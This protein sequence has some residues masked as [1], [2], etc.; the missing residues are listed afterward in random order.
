MNYKRPLFYAIL[1]S[2]NILRHY[3]LPPL[4][5]SFR[6]LEISEDLPLIGHFIFGY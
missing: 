6:G 3:H 4:E 2:E 5:I 1:N